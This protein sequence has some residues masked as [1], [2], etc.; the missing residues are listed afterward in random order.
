M[1]IKNSLRLSIIQALFVSVLMIGVYSC[2]N[3]D[4]TVTPTP[5][6]PEANS[7]SGT[8]TFTDTNFVTSGGFYDIGVFANPSTPPTYWFGPPTTNDTL[9]YSKVGNVYKGTY[10]LKGVPNGSYVV[11]LG[12]RKTSGGQSPIM[13]VYGC[14]TAR[15]VNGSACFLD[16]QRATITDNAGLENINFL[17]WADTTKKVY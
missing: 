5:T 10:K 15:F 16:P 2:S 11:A 17:A 7:I 4:T 3:D 13:G 14:D 8:I 12:F 1:K 9:H 6:G